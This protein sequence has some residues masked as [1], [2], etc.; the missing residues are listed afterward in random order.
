M[1]AMPMPDVHAADGEVN[2]FALTT[3]QK[4][5]ATTSSSWKCSPRLSYSKVSSQYAFS[6]NSSDVKELAGAQYRD[7]EPHIFG[8]RRQPLRQR[9][10]PDQHLAAYLARGVPPRRTF[11]PYREE[12]VG[13]F[14]N[15]N[16]ISRSHHRPPF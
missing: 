5:A 10:L 11:L 4:V 15:V 1:V 9:Q 3:A 13:F 2:C 6:R 14:A 7:G 8:I 12:L 16:G